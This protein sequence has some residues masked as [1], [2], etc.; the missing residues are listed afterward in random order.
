VL[1]NAGQVNPLVTIELHINLAILSPTF[2][3]LACSSLRLFLL[4]ILILFLLTCT[5]FR[6]QIL[7]LTPINLGWLNALKHWPSK[8]FTAVSMHLA[9]MPDLLAVVVLY[10]LVTLVLKP[11]KCKQI[12]PNFKVK[13]ESLS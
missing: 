5:S 8:I 11:K 1:L 6:L 2:V 7:A 3:N 4:S 13:S 9:G 12:V 10:S